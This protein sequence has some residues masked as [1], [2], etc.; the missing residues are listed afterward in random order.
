MIMKASILRSIKEVQEIK[1]EWASL[2]SVSNN[3]NP[4]LTWEWIRLWLDLEG[5]DLKIRVVVIKDKGSIVCIAPFCIKNKE[6]LFLSDSLFSDY[7]DIL[8]L[9]NSAEIFELIVDTIIQS[10]EWDRSDLLTIPESSGMLQ[11]YQPVFSKKTIFSVAQICHINPFIPLV[12]DFDDFIL[13]RSK[14][15]FK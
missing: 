11:H 7:M 4:F 13:K 3:Q 12:G 10:N 14:I 5:D 8:V 15:F 1:Y 2:Y 9:K 6:L